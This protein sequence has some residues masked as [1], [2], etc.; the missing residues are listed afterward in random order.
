[1]AF[2]IIWVS[3]LFHYLVGSVTSKEWLLGPGMGYPV[4][5]EYIVRCL[6]EEET[7]GSLTTVLLFVG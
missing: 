3:S 6:G 7:W 4:I 5:G 2:V 1:M